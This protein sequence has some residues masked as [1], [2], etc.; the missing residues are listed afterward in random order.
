LVTFF[1]ALVVGVASEPNGNRSIGTVVPVMAFGA[2]FLVG[3]WRWLD[4]AF[5]RYRNVFAA[6][7]VGVLLYVGANSYQNYLGPDARTLWGFY[8]ETTRVGLYMR[9]IA[10]DHEIY[11][12]AKNWPRDALTYLSYQGEG[13]PFAREYTY[14][15]DANELLAIE[16]ASDV[17]TAFIIEA[18]QQNDA[19]VETIRSRFPGTIVDPI[20]YP[21][22]SSNIIVRALLVP[23]GG[24]SQVR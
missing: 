5:P 14:F 1:L 19:V 22:G 18:G 24:D 13:N 3:S 23:P 17:G 12:A 21:D 10:S 2:V 11:A 7:L 15:V 9:D 4:E 8:P 16:P 6:G 20:Y